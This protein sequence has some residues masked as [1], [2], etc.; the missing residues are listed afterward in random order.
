[1]DGRKVH[2]KNRK[3]EEMEVQQILHMNG[4]TG[5]TSYAKNSIH[6]REAIIKAKHIVEGAILDLYCSVFPE[7]LGIADLGCSS[8]PNTLLV[9]SEIIDAISLQCCKLNRSWP[10][11]RVFLNDL[12]GNDFNTIFRSLPGFYEKLK[13]A[14]GID[15]GPCFILGVP[16]SFYGRLFP[17]KSLHFV[18]SSYSLH[19]LSQ[20]PQ[21][22]EDEMGISLN[23]G[24]MYLV[25]TTPP[26]VFKAY[27]EQ[28]QRDF[29]LFLKLRSEEI[30]KGGRMV[31]TLN[32]RRSEDPSSTECCSIWEL[33]SQALNDMISQ[34]AIE[35]AKLDSFNL[36]YYTPSVKELKAVIETEGSF[37]LQKLDIIEMNWD[38]NDNDDN[39]T[40]IFDKFTSGRTVANSIRAVAESMLATHFGE[41]V[42]D[43][44]FLRY[45]K[46]VVEH[47]AKEKTKHI[48]LVISLIKR[49]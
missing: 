32:G 33:M 14:K 22:L 37:T 9:I 19:W 15:F 5:E 46:N 40:I 17:S 16:G 2:V 43:D 41:A 23:E 47:L 29:S 3:R 49:E 28:F 20:V 11:F 8:G 38:G 12:P 42:I 1:M 21:G 13:K 10:E 31:L 39:K 4:G 34:G 44:L 48:N 45:E 35:K 7:S 26:L 30:I 27:L 36:P 18:H 6:E 25:K 24:N